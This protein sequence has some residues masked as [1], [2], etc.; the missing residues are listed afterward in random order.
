MKKTDNFKDE[1]GVIYC[2]DLVN[3]IFISKPALTALH[4][5][6]LHEFLDV[7]VSVRWNI[8][9]RLHVEHRS[10][11]FPPQPVLLLQGHGHGRE[12]VIQG[13]QPL[14]SE[15]VVRLSAEGGSVVEE[16]DPWPVGENVVIH[17][18]LFM[19]QCPGLVAETRERRLI[20]PEVCPVKNDGCRPFV[21][22]HLQDFRTRV[23]VRT[24]TS[25][26][27]ENAQG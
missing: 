3:L 16:P 6:V 9:V 2:P 19:K 27:I 10:Q 24:T 12:Q 25:G 11:A 22:L 4:L 23:S 7:S 17:R 26:W 1:S 21:E 5:N 14:Q 15:G 18:G 8:T 13:G 20:G